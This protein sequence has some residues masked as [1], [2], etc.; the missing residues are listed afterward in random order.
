MAE[1]N[2]TMLNALSLNDND[3]KIKVKILKVWRRKMNG[4]E[5]KFYSIE[6]I[7]MDEEVCI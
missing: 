1:E 5:N 4:E 7:L 6:M 2:V 3:C